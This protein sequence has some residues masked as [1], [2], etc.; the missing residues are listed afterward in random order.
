MSMDAS[1]LTWRYCWAE[2]PADEILALLREFA[3]QSTRAASGF[4]DTHQWVPLAGEDDV[5]I[6]GGHPA[7]QYRRASL[8]PAQ[9]ELHHFTAGR[10]EL[11]DGV[12]TARQLRRWL[13]SA[14]APDGALGDIIVDDTVSVI[15]SPAGSLDRILPALQE[16]ANWSLPAAS[17]RRTTAASGRADA[18]LTAL[19]NVSRGEAQTAIEY[20][21]VF[22]NFK[23]LAKRTQQLAAGDQIIYR[24]KGRS[25]L[26]SLDTNPRSGRVWVEFR[27]YPS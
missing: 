16:A 1:D 5:L 11:P 27:S 23:P 17:P 7:A 15:G 2:L 22:R 24:T 12:R 18:V 14:G 21:F 13:Y 10:S 25:E 9:P 6:D 3:T 19:F 26:I 8:A 20:G 4:L